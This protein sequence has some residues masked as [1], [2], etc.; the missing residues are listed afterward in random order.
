MRLLRLLAG[1][2]VLAALV[3]CSSPNPAVYT[4]AVQDGPTVLGTPKIIEMRDVGLAGYLDRP[5]IVRSSEGYRLAILA[6]DTWGEPLGGMIGRVLT[7]ELAQRLPNS[8]VYSDRSAISMSADAIVEVNI[9]RMDV[10]AD[11]D[12]L[13]LAQA[14]I[15]FTKKPQPVA[16]TFNIRKP[17]ADLTTASEVAAISAAVAELADGLA[18]MLRP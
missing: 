2:A 9:Q 16:R 7:V 13:L 18:V 15:K 14:A 4:I 12:L 17:V 10:N 3:A 11:G 5:N 1:T 6:N 8:N